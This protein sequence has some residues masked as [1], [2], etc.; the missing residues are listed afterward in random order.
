MNIIHRTFFKTNDR[1]QT[2]DLRNSENTNQDKLNKN[3]HIISQLL[4]T[5]GRKEI[6]GEQTGN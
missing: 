2:S 1:D 3:K 5:K 6:E 4:K